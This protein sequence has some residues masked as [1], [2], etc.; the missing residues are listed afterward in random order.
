MWRK[1][2][3]FIS[4]VFLSSALLILFLLQDEV[5]YNPQGNYEACF[6]EASATH[7]SLKDWQG[8]PALQGEL[9]VQAPGSCY[10]P[11]HP[12][13]AVSHAQ[14]THWI[15]L[16]KVNRDPSISQYQWRD[17]DGNYWFVDISSQNRELG[18][19]FYSSE[20]VFYDNPAWSMSSFSFKTFVWE[21]YVLPV[22]VTGPDVQ[23]LGGVHWGYKRAGRFSPPQ[24]IELSEVS[25]DDLSLELKQLA[26]M[27]TGYGFR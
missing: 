11:K 24:A 1:I 19:P 7:F 12:A 21:G 20:H 9:I 5:F 10:A 23:I 16:V 22:I 13:I 15:H 14:S 18:V 25:R 17:S 6:A 26:K 2:I 3:I 8:L 27:F 4:T